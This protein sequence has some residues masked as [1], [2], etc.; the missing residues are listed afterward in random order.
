MSR[1]ISYY[2]QFEYLKLKHYFKKWNY[3]SKKNNEIEFHYDKNFPGISIKQ[4]EKNYYDAK[5]KIN[6]FN[7]LYLDAIIKDDKHKYNQSIKEIREN[8]KYD[9]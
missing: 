8:K 6:V 7:R 1:I 9:K 2:S 4:R 5:E 3:I